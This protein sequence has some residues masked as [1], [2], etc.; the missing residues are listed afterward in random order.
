MNETLKKI[1]THLDSLESTSHLKDVFVIEYKGTR[2]V[3]SS[4]KRAWTTLASAKNALRNEIS[5]YK[6]GRDT[7]ENIKL[8][9]EAKSI[10]YIK[11]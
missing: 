10:R 1:V 11:L 7:L 6:Y 4:G 2:L 9:E 8:L 5:S 3:M